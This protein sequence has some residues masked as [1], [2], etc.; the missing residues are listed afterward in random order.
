M[1][2]IRGRNSYFSTDLSVKFS[3]KKTFINKKSK[4]EFDIEKKHEH[5][6]LLSNKTNINKN[7]IQ[8]ALSIDGVKL[9]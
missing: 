7:I 3:E 4:K 9:S 5:S 2:R 8:R 6:G 1:L